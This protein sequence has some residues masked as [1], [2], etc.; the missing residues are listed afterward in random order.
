MSQNWFDCVS[1]LTELLH[2]L[3]EETCT[4]SWQYMNYHS[5]VKEAW[6]SLMRSRLSFGHFSIHRI[7]GLMSKMAWSCLDRLGC[8]GRGKQYMQ[9]APARRSRYLRN[10]CVY[11]K[12]VCGCWNGTLKRINGGRRERK[13]PARSRCYSR[14][15]RTDPRANTSRQAT[16]STASY[17]LQHTASRDICHELAAAMANADVVAYNVAVFISTTFLLE[18]GADKFIDHTGIVARRTGISETIIGLVTAG[19]EWEEVRH[20]PRSDTIVSH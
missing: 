6:K 19:A 14:H 15:S 2:P 12:A 3:R 20:K 7:A 8:C 16:S 5:I 9:Q 17:S 13:K 4:N 18:V 10:L 1:E 11:A